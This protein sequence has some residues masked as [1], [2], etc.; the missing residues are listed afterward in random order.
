LGVAVRFKC[1]RCG[2]CCRLSPITVLPHEVIIIN[3]LAKNMGIS[4]EFKP[5]YGVY[6]RFS[7]RFIVLSYILDLSNNKCPFLGEGNKCIIHNLYKPLTCRSF[8]YLPKDVRY[9][10]D[11][12]N[13][14]IIHRSNY[15]ISLNCTFVKEHENELNRAIKIYGVR[16]VFPNEYAIAYFMESLRRHYLTALSKLWRSGLIDLKPGIRKGKDINAYSFLLTMYS[17]YKSLIK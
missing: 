6:D 11:D 13:K 10:F 8:P 4:I 1:L 14:I 16:G 2:K 7:G 3:R 9:Y 12:I 5:S 15:G 17:L